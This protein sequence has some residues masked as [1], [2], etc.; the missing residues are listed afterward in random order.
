MSTL[1]TAFPKLDAAID[2]GQLQ[3]IKVK[4]EP[5]SRAI[6]GLSHF[7]DLAQSNSVSAW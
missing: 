1:Q 7:G 6:G 2:F 4:L 5:A 3:V